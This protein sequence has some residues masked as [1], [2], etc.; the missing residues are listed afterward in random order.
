MKALRGLW[1]LPTNLL[2]H[3]AGLVVSGRR[4][5]RAGGPAAVGWL[6]PI[7]PGVGLDWVGAVTIGHA[8]LYTRGMLD[9]PS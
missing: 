5:R 3:L 2:G 4:P 6:Y 8:I 9:G 7:R 1:T